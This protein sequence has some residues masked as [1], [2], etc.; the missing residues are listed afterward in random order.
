MMVFTR[1][2]AVS[3]PNPEMPLPLLLGKVWFIETAC[4]VISSQLGLI[5]QETRLVS[6]LQPSTAA[7]RY[8]EN[9]R[10][11]ISFIIAW[12]M[13]TSRLLNTLVLTAVDSR[14]AR[15][16][17]RKIKYVRKKRRA[18]DEEGHKHVIIHDDVPSCYRRDEGIS[19]H[20]LGG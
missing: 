11:T 13:H 17:L 8:S 9:Q 12:S 3:I 7:Q 19:H 10:T 6:L 5:R 14:L 2:S 4:V 16:L 1:V 15:Y 20:T 18:S